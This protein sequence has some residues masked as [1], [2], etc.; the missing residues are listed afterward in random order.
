MNDHKKNPSAGES[1]KLSNEQ[2]KEQYFKKN[3][4]ADA[5]G[6]GKLSWPELHTH[7]KKGPPKKN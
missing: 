7:R 2:W 1:K 6:D 3:P 4:Q 5:N